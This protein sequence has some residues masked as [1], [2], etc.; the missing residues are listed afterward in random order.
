MTHIFSRVLGASALT[1]SVVLGGLSGAVVSTAPVLAQEAAFVPFVI[2]INGVP[3]T[4]TSLEQLASIVAA[5]PGLAATVAS[6][7]KVA[8]PALTAQIASTITNVPNVNVAAVQTALGATPTDTAGL[9][10]GGV[11]VY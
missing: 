8:N 2:L 10:T 4:V 5:N 7:A 9:P 11:P 3:V 1:L 6:A